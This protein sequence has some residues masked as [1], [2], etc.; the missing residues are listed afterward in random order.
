M[1]V[2]DLFMYIYKRKPS[3][4]EASK[5]AHLE[6]EEALHK[7]FADYIV[8]SP[9]GGAAAAPPQVFVPR[10]AGFFSVFNFLMGLL[11]NGTRAYPYYNMQAF[12]MRHGGVNQHFCYWTNKENAWMDYFEPLDD[13]HENITAAHGSLAIVSGEDAPCEFR[14]PFFIKLLMQNRDLWTLWRHR[15]NSVY[16]RHIRVRDKIQQ[17]VNRF[18]KANVI[19]SHTHY[20]IGVHY[21]HPSHFVEG[22]KIYFADYFRKIE[23][24]LRRIPDK[25]VFVKIFIASDTDVGIMAFTHRFKWVA[26]FYMHDV[27]RCSIDNFLEWAH[28]R[29]TADNMDFING[30]GYQYHYTKCAA[31][32]F[33]SRH[34]EDVL[35]E[36]LALSRCDCVV[37]TVSNVALAVSYM[38][39]NVEMHPIMAKT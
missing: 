27:E 16:N 34:G 31:K 3:K 10:D 20:I 30:V 21:R 32:D 28:A 7:A 36:V 39:P 29:G 13:E 18:W 8:S 17:R 38:N 4:E 15:V 22:G 23:E 11:Y 2:Q 33:S 26:P 9:P 14:G 35:C 5:Y 12:M 37:H 24:I 6:G 25:D 19:N 1:S